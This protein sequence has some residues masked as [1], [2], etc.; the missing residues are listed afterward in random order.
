MQE[1][2]IR[3]G[4]PPK[5]FLCTEPSEAL[6]DFLAIRGI[7]GGRFMDFFSDTD[8]RELLAKGYLLRGRRYHNGD[9]HGQS[10]LRTD[11]S[12]P[13]VTGG[14]SVRRRVRKLLGWDPD[15]RAQLP[16][17]P[18]GICHFVRYTAYGRLHLPGSVNVARVVVDEVMVGR[19]YYFCMITVHAADG[20]AAVT[21]GEVFDRVL[22]GCTLLAVAHSKLVVWLAGRVQTKFRGSM[23]ILEGIGAVDMLVHNFGYISPFLHDSTEALRIQ[24]DRYDSDSGEDSGTDS[25][26]TT[27]TDEDVAGRR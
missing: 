23:R 20:E 11:W 9:R 15:M 14:S 22:G 24:P 26:A 25:D 12:P 18:I 2:K 19:E 10:L 8:K 5:R 3:E 6:R 1:D 16:C 17:F 13:V 21:L 27:S 7:S 4:T